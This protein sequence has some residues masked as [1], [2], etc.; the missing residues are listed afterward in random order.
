MAQV[1]I[2]RVDEAWVEKARQEAARLKVSMNQVLVD[3]LRKGLG[4][5]VEPVRKAN[6]DRYAG[7]SDF[8]PGWDE[9]MGEDLQQVDDELWS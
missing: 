3:A 1:T 4:A 5:D 2:R 8:G 7:D 6:L 9:F